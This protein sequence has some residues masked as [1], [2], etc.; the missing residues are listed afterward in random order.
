MNTDKPND[1][2]ARRE[3]RAPKDDHLRV[4]KHRPKCRLID[5][6]RQMAKDA[7]HEAQALEWCEGLMPDAADM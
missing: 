4:S 2:Q 6:Y 3:R 5:G 7:E 1:P